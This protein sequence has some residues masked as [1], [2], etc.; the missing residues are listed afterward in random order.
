MAILTQSGRVAL[1]IA[2]MSQAIHLAWGAGD[3]AWDIAPVLEPADA[4][5]LVAEIGRHSVTDVRYCTPSDAGSIIVPDGRF[6]LSDTPTNYL[7]M[8]FNYDYADASTAEIRETGIFI[9]TK[10]DPKLPP[11]QVYFEGAQITAPGTLLMLE[12]FTKFPRSAASRQAF[13]F[14]VMF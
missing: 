7:F 10:T 4:K 6:E 13:E 1:A 2:V 8:R 3:P 11:G 14:V 5:S 12:R 9:G